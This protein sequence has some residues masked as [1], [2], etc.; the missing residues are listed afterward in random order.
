MN[1]KNT[2]SLKQGSI[3]AVASLVTRMI[4]MLYKIPLTYIVGE[5]GMTY[6]NAAYEVYNIALILSSLSITIAVSKLI[7]AKD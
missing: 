6:Y 3:L 4:G 5:D 7:S 2:N 1:S